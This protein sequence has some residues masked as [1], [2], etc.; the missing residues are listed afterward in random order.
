MLAIKELINRIRILA[1]DE[2]ET[3]YDDSTILFN[4][5]AGIRFINRI[6][7]AT[8]PELLMSFPATGTLNAGESVICV[9]DK[10]LSVL[11]VKANGRSLKVTS[12]IA[13]DLTKEAKEPIA[14]YLCGF[15]NIALW[16][17]PLEDVEYSI[18]YV[19]DTR[20][21]SIDDNSPFPNDFDD[22]L[23][24]YAVIRLSMGNEFEMSQELTVMQTVVN[25][26]TEIINAYP[27]AQYNID[28]YWDNN[29]NDDY[30]NIKS[31][32]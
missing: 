16:P 14:Y 6:I 30:G 19:K 21:L 2:V 9:N 24:E 20:E 10:I 32:W 26:I 23:I 11:A 17:T 18:F 4:I 1:H 31:W 15:E 12:P 5:N 7:K 28:G 25:Q 29:C 13:I 8:K 22:A 3:G 27:N